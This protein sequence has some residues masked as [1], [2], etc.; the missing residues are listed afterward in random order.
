M[1]GRL[2]EGRALP[3]QLSLGPAR[4][5][6]G[7][8]A[9]WA[10]TSRCGHSLSD[11]LRGPLWGQREVGVR[12]GQVRGWAEGDFSLFSACSWVEFGQR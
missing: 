4:H 1:Q 10:L 5:W 7:T 3:G 11:P 6:D 8:Q 12:A 9:L 2:G